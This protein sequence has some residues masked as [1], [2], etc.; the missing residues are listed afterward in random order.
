MLN[1]PA[2]LFSTSKPGEMKMKFDLSDRSHDKVTPE[3]GG[4][5]ARTL[6]NLSGIPAGFAYKY[7]SP[8][9]R[10]DLMATGAVLLGSS[11]LSAVT[12]TTGFH[13]ALGDGNF[14]PWYALAG[15][16]IGALTGAIDYVVQYKGTLSER[17][18]SALRRAG[19]NL[20]DSES[21]KTAPRLIRIGRI[22]QASTFGFLGGLF[23]IIA[24]DAADVRTYLDSK[25]IAANKV[26]AAEASKLVDA[27]IAR[28]RQALALQEGEVNNLSRS[29]QSL[30]SNDVRRSIGRKATSPVVASN[31]QLE[32]FEHRLADE[33]ARRDAL[34]ATLAAQEGARNSAV[35]KII[36]D[37]PDAVRKRSG[38][39]AEVEALSALTNENP[40]LL[41]IMLA[42]EFLSL[43]LELGPL[44]AASTRISS[45]LAARIALDHYIEVSA[46]ARDGAEKLGARGVDEPETVVLPDTGPANDNS[47]LDMFAT[48]PIGSNDN[49]P[50]HAGMNGATP[51]RRGR[52]R[53]RKN[54]L[55]LNSVEPGHKR[56]SGHD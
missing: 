25:F 53:P 54:G 13:L 17:G 41:V 27:S 23:F 50:P 7:G 39:S 32:A 19:L 8:Q 12:A 21:T 6:I 51:P 46:L 34:A 30:R 9:E 4:L 35:E 29:V 11:T 45:A 40:K 26:V 36:N 22:C 10:S 48:D 3:P 55:D 24:G 20:P 1:D 16:G 33:T 44:W 28:S 47:Q 43:C 38:L 42:I 49:E 56:G 14:N 18:L 52:G 2:C 15:L 31:P 5:I 37:S